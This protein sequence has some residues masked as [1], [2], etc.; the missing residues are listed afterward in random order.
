VKHKT[1]NGGGGEGVNVKSSTNTVYFLH[2]GSNLDNLI[3][4]TEVRIKGNNATSQRQT[5]L[6]FPRTTISSL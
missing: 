3:H 5:F 4:L 2:V 6:L 1:D